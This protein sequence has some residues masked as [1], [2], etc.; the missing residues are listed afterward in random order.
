MCVGGICF[1]DNLLFRLSTFTPLKK[2]EMQGVMFD[3]SP[4][5]GDQVSFRIE[6]K[7]DPEQSFQHESIYHSK[8]SLGCV[9][10][11]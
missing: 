8:F 9:C 1:K 2:K 7:G 4:G 5:K 3:L 6:E 11:F 10:F